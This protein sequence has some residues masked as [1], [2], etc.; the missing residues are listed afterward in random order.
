M[1]QLT[2]EEIKNTIAFINRATAT[3]GEVKQVA[4]PLLTKLTAM[5]EEMAKAE[6]THPSPST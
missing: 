2:V 6:A 3:V 4:L 5:V 1:I